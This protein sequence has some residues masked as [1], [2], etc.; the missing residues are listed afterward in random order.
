MRM[1]GAVCTGADDHGGPDRGVLNPNPYPDPGPNLKLYFRVRNGED[2]AAGADDHGGPARGELNPNHGPGPDVYPKFNPDRSSTTQ[3][4]MIT[5]GQFVAYAV[6]WGF[7]FAPGTWR[8]M[9]G[10][11]AAPAL[12][13]AA[14]LAF[15]PESPRYARV[16]AR[17]YTSSLTPLQ[18]PTEP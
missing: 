13:Q 6:D 2:P 16:S 18:P 8:W 5:V 9:L 14:G 17:T 10:V 1:H 11:A 12:L 4:L 3:V 7:T 15:L